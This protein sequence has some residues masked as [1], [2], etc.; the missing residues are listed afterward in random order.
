MSK[1]V[2]KSEV[3]ENSDKILLKEKKKKGFI[4][5]N[6][7]GAGFDNISLFVDSKEMKKAI[8]SGKKVFSLETASGSYD[9]ITK[10]VQ[11]HPISWDLL[12]V[13]F[14][15]LSD[16]KK[17]TIKIPLRY[18]GVAFGVKN[19]GG[20]LLLNSRVVEVSC[21]PKHILE[22]IVVDVTALKLNDTI[23]AGD[24]KLE[25]ITDISYPSELL[26]K[27]GI[28]RSAMSEGGSA[29]E[30]ADEEESAEES[31]ETTEVS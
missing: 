14:L 20:V 13:D 9:V 21:L 29:G 24:L 30:D 26:C 2:I 16:D 23:H 8:K 25:N 15:K 11:R 12:H 4:P 7:Y 5:A 6:L 22:E 28:T 31:A 1:Y 27:V 17:V 18:E 10:E 19:M 3:K